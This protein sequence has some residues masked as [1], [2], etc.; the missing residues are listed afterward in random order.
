MVHPP[1]RV[2]GNKTQNSTTVIPCMRIRVA[3]R[4]WQVCLCLVKC[5]SV[6]QSPGETPHRARVLA[7]A[8]EMAQRLRVH[9]I[10]V[11]DPSLP[12]CQA[13]TAAPG[14]WHV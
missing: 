11:E 6:N 8:E 5:E 13:V 10:F 12:L 1:D 14:V 4:E 2:L 7:L 9:T 3:L